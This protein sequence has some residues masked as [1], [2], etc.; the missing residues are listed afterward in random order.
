ML[1]LCVIG[2]ALQINWQVFYSIEVSLKNIVLS[3]IKVIVRLLF[4]ARRRGGGLMLY[5][6]LVGRTSLYQTI[7][8]YI[9]EKEGL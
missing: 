1:F 4:G 6:W 3:A 8:L 9:V 5:I 2:N 7:S